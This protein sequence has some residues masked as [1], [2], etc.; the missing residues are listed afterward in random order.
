MAAGI[1]E[2]L[3]SAIEANTA[4]QKD[5]LAALKGGKTTSSSSASSEDK[6]D[7]PKASGTKAAGAKG[8]AKGP[9][10]DDVAKVFTDY[11]SV[12]DKDEREERKKNVRAIT[13]HFGVDR[14]TEIEEGDRQDAIDK[15][16]AFIDGEDPFDGEGGE[17][18]EDALV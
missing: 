14:A 18:N 4:A 11:L 16:Q 5:V 10:V 12:K 17:E 13:A 15:L 3:I 9:T 2:T 8:K 1:L 6:E 7:K